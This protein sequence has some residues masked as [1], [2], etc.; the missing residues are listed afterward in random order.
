MGLALEENGMVDVKTLTG[1][2][3]CGR[4]RFEVTADLSQILACNC[5]ICTKRGLLL[6][7]V[8]P[9]NFALRAG[10]ED[11]LVDYQFNRHVIHHL[12][13]PVC[14]VESYA[15]GRLPDGA[16]MVAVNVR[17]LDHIELDSLALTPFDGLSL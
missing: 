12:F 10:E 8:K 15:R 17:C 16:E 1:G 14:G 9:E 6:T 4:V 3:H 7:F 5:S 11:E 2:C 13:C